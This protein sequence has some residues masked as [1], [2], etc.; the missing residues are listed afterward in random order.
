MGFFHKIHKW[1]N[2]KIKKVGNFHNTADKGKKGWNMGTQ[3][4]GTI[5]NVFTKTVKPKPKPTPPKPTPPKPNNDKYDELFAIWRNAAQYIR[6]DGTEM[7]DQNEE[8]SD[9]LHY[10][11]KK[12]KKDIDKLPWEQKNMLLEMD[13]WM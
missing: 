9:Y 1:A 2:S 13:N 5:R 12:F 7:D 6:M 8:K 10:L 3:I 4:L 11:V